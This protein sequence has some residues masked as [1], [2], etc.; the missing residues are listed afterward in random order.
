MHLNSRARH[1]RHA[2]T[3]LPS[4]GVPS[5]LLFVANNLN[6]TARCIA[7]QELRPRSGS[8]KDLRDGDASR[9]IRARAMRTCAQRRATSSRAAEVEGDVCEEERD[10]TATTAPLLATTS[11]KRVR[12]SRSARSSRR[13][14]ALRVFS[15]RRIRRNSQHDNRCGPTEQPGAHA[16]RVA[17]VSP[18]ETRGGGHGARRRRATGRCLANRS[19]LGGSPAAWRR[20]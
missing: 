16:P 15:E 1:P 3:Q 8:G 20:R 12:S 13:H 9:T 2:G 5:Q 7:P 17:V 18:G 10:P 11:A 14:R 4:V 6:V 19:L